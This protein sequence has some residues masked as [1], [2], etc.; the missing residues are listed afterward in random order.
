MD[1]SILLMC[2][3]LSTMASTVTGVVMM[4]F[5]LKL[6]ICS[7]V[8]FIVFYVFFNYFVANIF[9]STILERWEFLNFQILAIYQIKAADSWTIF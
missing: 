5:A 3:M 8:Y 2:F 6:N 1:I 7:L 4:T 9:V